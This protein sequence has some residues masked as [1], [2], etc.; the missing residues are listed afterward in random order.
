MS[1]LAECPWRKKGRNRGQQERGEGEEEEKGERR[2]EGKRREEKG[3]GE[4]GE[5]SA[6]YPWF[7]Q[8]G[9]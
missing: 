8:A 2:E 1:W 6:A 9:F 5:S 4:E 3:E 7:G